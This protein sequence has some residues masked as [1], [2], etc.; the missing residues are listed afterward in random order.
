[1][2]PFFS[3]IIPVY[4]AEKY[5]DESIGSVL[6]QTFKN[7]EVIL[8]N[9]GSND[10]SADICDKYGKE[11]PQIITVLHKENEGQI[12]A[13]FEG[14]K[15]AKGKYISYLD[16]DDYLRVDA[17]EQVYKTI[18][19]KS[20]EII[21]FQWQR[22]KMNG[23]L[24]PEKANNLFKDGEICK[25]DLFKKMLDT[26]LLNTM[27]LKI[28]KSDLFDVNADYKQFY[29]V[30]HGED[31]LQSLDLVS[32]A[33]KIYYLEKQLYFYRF[34]PDSITNKNN[35]M[36]Y[37]ALNRVFPVLYKYIGIM[38]GNIEDNILLFFKGGL[39]SLWESLFALFRGRD[40]RAE[41]QEGLGV[42]YSY[43][44]VKKSKSYLCQIKIPKYMKI[45]L[46][47]F[48]LKYWKLLT[49]YL[50]SIEF[51][52]FGIRRTGLYDIYQSVFKK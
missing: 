19:T 10:K 25:A 38:G 3:V 36:K 51:I 8:V 2:D 22:V 17:L 35:K 27:C 32:K 47:L 7:Y 45:G 12:S 18:E 14:L 29:D 46:K 1:M 20:P 49:C 15:I 50:A 33:E 44:V 43:D 11:Y 28:C 6:K 5:L 30:R 23:E 34:N 21:I 26:S 4:N 16:A 24:I 42:I 41:W 48:Y 39:V 13:R 40:T 9:D 37:T 31:L 52:K